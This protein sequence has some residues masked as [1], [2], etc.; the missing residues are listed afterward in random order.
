MSKTTQKEAVY[1]AVTGFYGSKFSNGMTHTKEDKA[2]IVDIL[3][4]QF[5]AG[6][7]EIKSAQENVRTY[8]IGLLNNHLRK[9]TRL[10][11]GEKYV[12]KNPGSRA[13]QSNPQIAAQ[14]MIGFQAQTNMLTKKGCLHGEGLPNRIQ[15]HACPG[16]SVRCR[17]RSQSFAVGVADEHHGHGDEVSAAERRQGISPWSTVRIADVF[18][19]IVENPELCSGVGHSLQL[20]HQQTL[21]PGAAQD[22]RSIAGQ[23][24]RDGWIRGSQI[25]QGQPSGWFVRMRSGAGEAR[26][27]RPTHRHVPAIN[28]HAQSVVWHGEDG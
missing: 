15:P 3:V 24:L 14:G 17:Q 4:E 20:I 5:E 19:I 26:N 13:G 12:A 22:Q 28:L 6:N 16:R 11:G 10:N 9:D 18:R 25:F 8:M 2:K 21:R 27:R 1:L 7:I 23:I